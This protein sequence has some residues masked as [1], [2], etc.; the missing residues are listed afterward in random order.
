[1]PVESDIWNAIKT[2][3]NTIPLTPK[4]PVAWPND[5]P[6]AKPVG[7]SYLRVSHVPNQSQR[8]FL[9]SDDPHRLQGIAQIDVFTPLQG[10]SNASLVMVAAVVGHFPCDL[11]LSAGETSLRITKKPDPM[12]GMPGD[13]HWQVPIMVSYEA[14]A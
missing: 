6:F 9:G 12:P 3:A 14:F 2:R 8:M 4:P 7:S 10:G 5:A 1:M 11:V 13:T